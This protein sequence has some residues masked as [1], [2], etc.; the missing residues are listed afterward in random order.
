MISRPCPRPV[1]DLRGQRSGGLWKSTN[2]GSPGGTSSTTMAV[3][4]FGTW[5]S[6]PRTLG[7]LR[8]HGR[9]EQPPEHLMG[10]RRLPL[11][12]RW[13]D[14][15]P[16]GLRGDP[17]HRQDRGP[18]VEPR[19]GLRGGP[20]ESLGA[21]SETVEFSEHRRRAELGARSSL[22]TTT[23]APST[24]SWIPHPR[25][26]LRRHVPAPATR[27][28]IQRRRAGK[29]DLQDDGRGCELDGAHQRDS[30]GRQGAHRPRHLGSNP[31]VLNAI[32]EHCR[33]GRARHLPHRGR[34][35]ELGAG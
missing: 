23:R 34:G 24:W 5:P 11:R 18:P 22:S 15:A 1:H 25:R 32:V 30:P 14:L 20:G 21:Q 9:A 16:P 2:R 4:T 26:P 35:S 10:Q 6:P 19:R 7:G 27:L 17:A 31:R 8:R 28:G 3:S 12:R 33:P 29:R 13:S